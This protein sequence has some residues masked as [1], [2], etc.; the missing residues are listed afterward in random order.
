MRYF[1]VSWHY[2]TYISIYL[3]LLLPYHK[4]VSFFNYKQEIK[5]VLSLPALTASTNIPIM[6]HHNLF[7]RVDKTNNASAIDISFLPYIFL[8]GT[9]IFFI[10]ILIQ[11][12]KIY[13]RIF[14]VCRL[15]NDLQFKNILLGCKQEMGISKDVPLYIST[16]I[17]TPFLYGVIKP[18]IVLPDIQFTTEELQHVF[19]HELT[20]WKRHDTWLKCMMLLINAFHWFNPFVYLIRHDIDRFN[21]LSCDESVVNLMNSDERRRYCELMLGV[22]WNVTVLNVKLYSAFSDKRKQLERRMNMIMKIEG[23]KSRRWLRMFAAVMTLVLIAG[24]A[25]TVY[26]ATSG[27]ATDSSASTG[28]IILANTKAGTLVAE[29]YTNDELKQSEN[30]LL[31][32]VVNDFNID[33][34]AWYV[35]DL[36]N[37]DAILKENF[38]D[39][40]Y[41]IISQ[42]IYEEYYNDKVDRQPNANILLSKEL[43]TV[44]IISEDSNHKILC[45]KTMFDNLGV[46]EKSWDYQN[47]K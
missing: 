17:S 42:M 20:H 38:N 9:L 29:L 35:S 45:A 26:A 12:V 24:G 13:H 30:D 4:L 22:L 36:E 14:A 34:D 18:S 1:K 40:D 28:Q 8:A 39:D 7:E 25:I 32:R 6:D 33:T 2:Y 23:L 47:K 19:Q 41:N 16:C 21:E 15:S 10:V 46:N 31:A 3:F 11:N 37:I 43:N 44:M 27:K 5:T